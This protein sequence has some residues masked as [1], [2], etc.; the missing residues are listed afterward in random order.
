[1][2][3]KPPATLVL[4]LRLAPAL[5]SIIRVGLIDPDIRGVALRAIEENRSDDFA[6]W[7]HLEEIVRRDVATG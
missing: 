3:A 7:G 4:L 2:S 6:E 5:D 1:M